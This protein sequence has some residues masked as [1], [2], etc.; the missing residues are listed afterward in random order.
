MGVYV[1]YFDQRL[2]AACFIC[3]EKLAS[4]PSLTNFS[5][6]ELEIGKVL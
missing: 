2:G 5:F 3:F 4:P 6:G 1:V